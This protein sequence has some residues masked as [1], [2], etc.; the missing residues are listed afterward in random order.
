MKVGASR[1][2]TGAAR[3]VAARLEY[4]ANINLSRDLQKVK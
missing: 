2:E 3:I 4:L 1:T